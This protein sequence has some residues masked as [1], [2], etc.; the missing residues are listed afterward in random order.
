MSQASIISMLG[1]TVWRRFS[2]A[3]EPP[4][5]SSMVKWIVVYPW[6]ICASYFAY[7]YFTERNAMKTIIA[8]LEKEESND[9]MDSF[10]P[11]QSQEPTGPVSLTPAHKSRL[12]ELSMTSDISPTHFNDFLQRLDAGEGLDSVVQST[13]MR[14]P[15]LTCAQYVKLAKLVKGL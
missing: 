12:R 1:R 5:T 13:C 9:A 11:D 4:T 7:E 3:Q 8:K 14:D 6:T 15:P 10:V 2:Q